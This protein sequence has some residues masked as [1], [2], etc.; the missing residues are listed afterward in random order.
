MVTFSSFEGLDTVGCTFDA[1]VH[2]LNGKGFCPPARDA[3]N[4]TIPFGKL[5]GPVLFINSS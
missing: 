1:S 4:R 3:G 5:D 2:Q